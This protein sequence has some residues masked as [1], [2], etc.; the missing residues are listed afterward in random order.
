[1]L[2]RLS[3][4]SLGPLSAIDQECQAPLTHLPFP[5]SYA[6][7]TLAWE[8]PGDRAAIPCHKIILSRSLHFSTASVPN[9]IRVPSHVSRHD[10]LSA[11]SALYGAPSQEPS[12]SDWAMSLFALEKEQDAQGGGILSHLEGFACRCE[13][14]DAVILLREEDDQEEGGGEGHVIELPVHRCPATP[15]SRS[16]H[17]SFASPAVFPT[18]PPN[19][20]YPHICHLQHSYRA[21]SLCYSC[22]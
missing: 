21:I 18:H 6:D 10:A 3:H 17:D 14:A 8:P 15:P 22:G 4:T 1:M 7:C 12:T 19:P 20:P 11:L 13:Y 16:L 9:V 5:Q 2:A